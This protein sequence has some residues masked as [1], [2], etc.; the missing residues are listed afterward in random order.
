MRTINNAYKEK[1]SKRAG[2]LRHCPA[3]SLVVKGAE[4]C[5]ILKKDVAEYSADHYKGYFHTDH[6]LP[7]V[8]FQEDRDPK[9]LKLYQDLSLR[10][11]F[12]PTADP[13]DHAD[14]MQGIEANWYEVK[15]NLDRLP[16][17]LDPE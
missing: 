8:F 5:P 1:P 17:S 15:H 12:D 3:T 11:I 13:Q 16:R 10:Y 2:A 4:S 7:S 6:L 9:E 14:L